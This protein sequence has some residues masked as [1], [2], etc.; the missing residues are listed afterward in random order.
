MSG[1]RARHGIV[2]PPDA[3]GIV[4]ELPAQGSSEPAGESTATIS[5][6]YP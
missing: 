4:A 3:R 6:R 5:T 2:V 1:L